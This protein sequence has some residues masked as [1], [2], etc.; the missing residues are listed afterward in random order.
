MF[1]FKLTLIFLFSAGIAES[2]SSK[3]L[4][5]V[6]ETKVEYECTVSCFESLIA[7]THEL[8][9]NENLYKTWTQFCKICGESDLTWDL[10]RITIEMIPKNEKNNDEITTLQSC[11]QQVSKKIIP[12]FTEQSDKAHEL[13]YCGVIEILAEH[14]KPVIELACNTTKNTDLKYTLIHAAYEKSIKLDT[15][16]ES[17]LACFDQRPTIVGSKK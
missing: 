9:R 8:D 14:I 3:K 10:G 2:V 6:E 12:L 11:L 15:P 13:M 7:G 17:V 5:L 4:N 16:Y 1:F